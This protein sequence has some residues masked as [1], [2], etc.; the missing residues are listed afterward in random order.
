[1]KRLNEDNINSA[2]DSLKYSRSMYLNAK[3]NNLDSINYWL[4]RVNSAKSRIK[5]LQ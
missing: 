4:E 2:I 3:E 1:M 5:Y